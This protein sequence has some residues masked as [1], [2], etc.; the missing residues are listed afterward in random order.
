MICQ[1][2]LRSYRLSVLSQPTLINHSLPF[3]VPVSLPY[4]V[5]LSSISTVY[6]L[7]RQ[8]SFKFHSVLSYHQMYCRQGCCIPLCMLKMFFLYHFN[9][10]YV[11]RQHSQHTAPSLKGCTALFYR[12]SSAITFTSFCVDVSFGVGDVYHVSEFPR[13]N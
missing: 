6:F 2:V 1:F 8:P 5:K 9:L 10:I 4:F 12:L 7:L 13:L 11:S 3:S